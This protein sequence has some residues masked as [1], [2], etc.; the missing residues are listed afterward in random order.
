MV[1]YRGIDVSLFQG[2][3][4]WRKVRADGVEF[5]MI[6][7]SQG[8]TGD[9]NR[10]FTDPK[11]QQN[12]TGAGQAGLYWG[13]Y[14]YLS[15]GSVIEARQ[16]AEY[17]VNLVKPYYDEMKLWAAVDVEDDGTVGRLTKS[18]VTEIVKVFCDIVRAAGLRPM[19]Y[20]NTYWLNS[21]FDAPAGIP[22]WATLNCGMQ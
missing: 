15:A 5:A 12:R 18:Q 4:D 11:F 17:Y 22:I 1:E 14:H 21:K 2:D 9:Y 13:T 19:V 3:V 6:K 8:R 7:A 10:P 16:E 20:A